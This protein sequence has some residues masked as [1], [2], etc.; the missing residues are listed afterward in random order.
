MGS[1]SEYLK[2]GLLVMIDRQFAIN[3]SRGLE[4]LRAFSPTDQ[5]LGNRELCERTSLP[6]ATVSRLTY[7]LEKLGYLIRVDRLQKYRLGPG[8]LMLGYP[9]LAGMEIRHLIRPY[10]EKLAAKTKWTVNLGMLG[11]L[12]VVYIDAMRLDRKNFLKPDIGS[13]RPLLTTSIGRALLLASSEGD[14]DSILNRLKIDN[15]PEFKKNL[16]HF[17][18]DKKHYEKNSYCISLGDWA[19]NV[20]AVAVP[21]RVG[22]SDDPPIALNCTF[23]GAKINQSEIQH[24]VIPYLLEAKH[25]IEK[26][27][28]SI[29]I[30]R[31]F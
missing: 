21:L 6:K 15:P 18:R 31:R 28:G 22:S 30:S 4:V 25:N 24:S 8:V 1:G 9:M 10:M 20:C 23:S 13:S 12:E 19:L 16:H 14:Q 7:T 17:Y 11:R 29:Y 26:D 3:L 2:N 27:N 5:L